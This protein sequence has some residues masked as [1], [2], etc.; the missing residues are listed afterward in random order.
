MAD[1]ALHGR[2]V[3]KWSGKKTSSGTGL[4]DQLQWVRDEKDRLATAGTLLRLEVTTAAAAGAAAPQT[5]AHLATGSAAEIGGLVDADGDG[6]GGLDADEEKYWHTASAMKNAGRFVVSGGQGL[7][8]QLSRDQV[9]EIIVTGIVEHERKMKEKQMIPAR[10][11]GGSGLT[12]V[13][14]ALVGSG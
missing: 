4:G 13:V 11:G 5:I 6:G 9:E 7:Q 1:L 3:V 14:N 12:S 2:D 10:G 8:Q